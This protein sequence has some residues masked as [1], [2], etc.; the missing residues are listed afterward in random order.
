M[1]TVL[2]IGRYY[3]RSKT[4]CLFDS[5]NFWSLRSTLKFSH[6]CTV[7]LP[8]WFRVLEDELATACRDICELIHVS[9]VTPF[10]LTKELILAHSTVVSLPYINLDDINFNQSCIF[11]R[12]VMQHQGSLGSSPLQVFLLDKK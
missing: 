7:N 12:S 10:A 3:V 9:S 5:I 8:A 6:L 2:V 11:N 4:V 1:A